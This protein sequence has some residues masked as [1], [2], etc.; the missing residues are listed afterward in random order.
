MKSSFVGA[1]S[2]CIFEKKEHDLEVNIF[3]YVVLW[4][5]GR[6]TRLKSDICS[7]LGYSIEQM[8]N[9]DDTKTPAKPGL[10]AFAKYAAATLA[11]VYGPAVPFPFFVYAAK[12]KDEKTGL[13]AVT[14]RV[15]FPR[16]L[17]NADRQHSLLIDP[18][19]GSG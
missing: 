16:I 12:Y 9:G 5:Q 17:V 7:Y 14:T 6:G 15:H 11:E 18:G 13:P 2:H 3:F 19:L 8:L 4:K 1:G 10:L